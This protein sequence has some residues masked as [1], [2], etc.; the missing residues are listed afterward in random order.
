SCSSSV[1]P[2]TAITLLLV[3]IGAYAFATP[4]SRTSA[5]QDSAAPLRETSAGP[6][7]ELIRQFDGS[8]TRRDRVDAISRLSGDL[9]AAAWQQ[10]VLIAERDPDFEARKEA[11]SYIAGRATAAAGQELIRL[12]G[13][14][15]S[16]R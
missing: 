2:I 14:R 5:H 12:D 16:T 15:K 10:L 1:A 3:V 6:T 4:G 7:Q 13:D 11:V 9:S 8:R